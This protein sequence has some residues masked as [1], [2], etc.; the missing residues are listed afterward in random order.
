MT[1][2]INPWENK[3]GLACTCMQNCEEMKIDVIFSA[4]ISKG[5]VDLLCSKQYIDVLCDIIT[6]HGQSTVIEKN[7][8]LTFLIEWVQILSCD[9]QKHGR[10]VMGSNQ[11]TKICITCLWTEALGCWLCTTYCIWGMKFSCKH[12]LFI[13]LPPDLNCHRLNW[14]INILLWSAYSV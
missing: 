6:E 10:K 8:G 4:G 1:V 11:S 3:P 5:W 12:C 14:D 2:L 13:L 7:Y 9:P